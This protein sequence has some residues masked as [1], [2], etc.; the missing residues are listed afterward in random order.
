[1]RVEL[2]SI[3]KSAEDLRF[4]IRADG[5]HAGGIT[6][7]SMSGRAFSYG[8]AI[9]P[10]MRRQGIARRA[11]RLLFAQMAGRGFETARVQVAPGN[12]ASLALH[13]ALGFEE[14]ARTAEAVTLARSLTAQNEVIRND[15]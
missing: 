15:G 5:S 10:P 3:G 1:M 4:F 9:A 6:V 2:I 8:I 7:H 11:L 12:A 13:R 14:C